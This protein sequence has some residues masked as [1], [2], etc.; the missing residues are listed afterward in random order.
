MDW[1]NARLL[2][3]SLEL[4]PF[5]QVLWPGPQEHPQQQVIGLEL[6]PFEQVLWR[7]EAR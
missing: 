6:E 1:S 2:D 7:S 4:E 3:P 5:E